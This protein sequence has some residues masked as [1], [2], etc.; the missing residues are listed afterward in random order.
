MFTSH[1][2]KINGVAA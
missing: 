2:T 1:K